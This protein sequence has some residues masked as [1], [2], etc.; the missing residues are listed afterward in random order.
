MREGNECVCLVF[1]V[2]RVRAVRCVVDVVFF[3]S[4][5][6]GYLVIEYFHAPVTQCSLAQLRFQV[7]YSFFFSGAAQYVL[8][9]DFITLC[10]QVA[11][12]TLQRCIILCCE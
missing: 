10:I 6:S 7:Y 4:K 11:D 9:Y 5:Y 12:I 1:Q 2:A 3:V 8:F